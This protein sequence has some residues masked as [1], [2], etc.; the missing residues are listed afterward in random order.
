MEGLRVINIDQKYIP[1]RHVHT[2]KK[3]S[4]KRR[5]EKKAT[6]KKDPR[7]KKAPRNKKALPIIFNL[8]FKV[9]L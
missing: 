8:R 3:C 1:F 9:L 4:C 7:K 5:Q 6:V 2:H